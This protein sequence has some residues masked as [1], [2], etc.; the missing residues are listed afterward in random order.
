MPYK[1]RLTG[2]RP[3]IYGGSAKLTPVVVAGLQRATQSTMIELRIVFGKIVSKRLVII[4]S[5]LR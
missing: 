4:L 1:S 2:S 5:Q 3:K